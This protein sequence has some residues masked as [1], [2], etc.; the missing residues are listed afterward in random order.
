MLTSNESVSGNDQVRVVVI[1][2]FKERNAYPA[3][4]ELQSTRVG[5][6]HRTITAAPFL[7]RDA[8]PAGGRGPWGSGVRTRASRHPTRGGPG[9]PAGRSGT[10]T[11][12]SPATTA[13]VPPRAP[14][15][16]GLTLGAGTGDLGGRT[17]TRPRRTLSQTH[18]PGTEQRTEVP[19]VSL[20][21]LSFHHHPHL[22]R[23]PHIHLFPLGKWKVFASRW[24]ADWAQGPSTDATLQACRTASRA[25]CW[26]GRVGRRAPGR[27]GSCSA[28]AREAGRRGLSGSWLR[29]HVVSRGATEGRAL[30]TVSEGAESQADTQQTGGRWKDSI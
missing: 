11:T 26:P 22:P 12:P 3:I 15:A 20:P 14:G 28:G 18:T 19:S 27:Q 30:L 5:R 16:A 2:C 17:P 21:G 1:S 8:G 25:P 9:D 4:P 6:C 29:S 13:S 10:D 23:S 24:F 7:Y